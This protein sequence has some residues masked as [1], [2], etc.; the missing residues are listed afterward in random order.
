MEYLKIEYSNTYDFGDRIL[1]QTDFGN[2]VY[3]DVN[4]KSP[5]YPIEEEAVENGDKDISLTF[6]KWQKRYSFST[7]VFEFMADALTLLPLHDYIWITFPNGESNRVTDV[8]VEVDFQDLGNTD[9][10]NACMC[11]VN[12]S[13]A[14]DSIIT[15][16]CNNNME[17][18]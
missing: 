6:Q 3:L 11:R 5:T 12:V 10:T 18:A 2:I 7:L 8:E 14:V 4:V 9:E 15:T 1:Y 16:G 17:I 13:F